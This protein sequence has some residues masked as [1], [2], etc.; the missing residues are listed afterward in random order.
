MPKKMGPTIPHSRTKAWTRTYRQKWPS[1]I[2]LSFAS[3]SRVRLAPN[4]RL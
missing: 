2:L 4:W 1:A 3:A